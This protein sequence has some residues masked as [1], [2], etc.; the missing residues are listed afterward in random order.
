M[1]AE[2]RSRS[3][4][5]SIGLFEKNF[6]VLPEHIVVASLPIPEFFDDKWDL[7]ALGTNPALPPSSHILHFEKYEDSWKFVIK[8]ILAALINFDHPDLQRIGFFPRFATHKPG[9][10][11]RREHGL[12]LIYK[13]ARLN[14]KSAVFEDWS[15][16]DVIR[17]LAWLKHN[18]AKSTVEN[19]NQCLEIIQDFNTI[20]PSPLHAKVPKSTFQRP[21][22]PVKTEPIAPDDFWTLLK[23]C[24]LFINDFSDDILDARD[25]FRRLRLAERQIKESNLGRSKNLDKVLKSYLE[26]RDNFIPLH[27][28][29]TLS[30]QRGEINWSALALR[31]GHSG[32][33]LGSTTRTGRQRRKRIQDAINSGFPTR[34]GGLPRDPS[35]VT[36]PDGTKKPWCDGLDET[37][38]QKP[39]H[40]LHAAC[41]IFISALTLMRASE[42]KE[43]ECNSI[44][45]RYGT[46]AINSRVFKHRRFQ[47]EEA[48]WWVTEP[49]VKAVKVAE[50]IVGKGKLFSLANLEGRGTDFNHHHNLKS[51]VSYHQKH[52]EEFGLPKFRDT[53]IAAHRL[54]RTMAIITANQPN[55]IIALGITL[56]HNAT[57]NIANIVTMGY[58]VET[59]GWEKE[60]KTATQKANAAQL[61]S[62]WSKKQSGELDVAGPGARQFEAKMDN[63]TTRISSAQ[64]TSE[65]QLR[66]LLRDEF[67]HIE[68]GTF[69]HCLGNTDQ[70]LCLAGKPAE[71]KQLGPTLTDCMRSKCPNSVITSRHLDLWISRE[72]A[73]KDLLR[74]KWMAKRHRSRLKLELAE[75]QKVLESAR[76][77]RSD[78][79]NSKPNS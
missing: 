78:E 53:K 1:P 17:L 49:V 56:K 15:D 36:L 55:G 30:A 37:S 25:E 26:N 5:P 20:L 14:N 18:Y 32:M 45:I 67:S 63:V 54:R 12:S 43:I 6:P 11:R 62:E 64:Y 28:S 73:I 70:A 75:I 68:L 33:F 21:E 51:F 34:Y 77:A 72:R 35:L 9:T 69:N 39:L 61:V 42:V 46:P 71:K 65:R 22:K 23:S 58:S 13:W 79:I 74:D 19:C 10:L 29:D 66:D 52:A 48:F 24:W 47:G 27:V 31:L 57:Q 7:R 16:T 44:S 60:F 4:S 40:Q 50:R 59:N 38:L 2:L 76:K 3:Q 8:S 41:F